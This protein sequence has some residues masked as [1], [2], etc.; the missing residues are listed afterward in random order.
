MTRKWRDNKSLVQ[1][2]KLFLIDEVI[3]VVFRLTEEGFLTYQ[4]SFLL[5]NFADVLTRCSSLFQG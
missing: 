1:L 2:V 5:E 3:H 4:L